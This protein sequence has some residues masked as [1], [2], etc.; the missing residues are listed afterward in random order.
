MVI[1]SFGPN[2]TLFICLN[3][4]TEIDYFIA[5]RDLKIKICKVALNQINTV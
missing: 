4:D 3:F 1:Y 5:I 2:S